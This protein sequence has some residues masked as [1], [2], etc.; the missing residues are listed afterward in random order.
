VTRATRIDFEFVDTIPEDVANG[1]L[2]ISTKYATVVH[3]CCCG[4]GMEVVTPLARDQWSLTFD[5]ESVSLHPS[6]GNWSFACQSHYWIRNNQ[7]RWARKFSQAEI[8][9]V[10]GLGPEVS[11]ERS[12]GDAMSSA[13]QPRGLKRIVTSFASFV[14]GQR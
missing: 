11:V 10:R 13:K 9:D 4:C 1:V 14:R 8:K 7:I 3:R 2:Y 5:G 6:V 12:V